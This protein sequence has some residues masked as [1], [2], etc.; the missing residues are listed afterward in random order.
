M[1]FPLQMQLNSL[2]LP[3]DLEAHVMTPYG[4]TFLFLQVNTALHVRQH[5]SVL[6]MLF[7][8]TLQHYLI[9]IASI[10]ISLHSLYITHKIIVVTELHLMTA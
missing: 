8:K 6:A 2:R 3:L 7:V 4:V 10:C 1:H 5:T 9:C